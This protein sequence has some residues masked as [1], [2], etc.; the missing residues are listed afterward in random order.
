MKLRIGQKVSA[1]FAVVMALLLVIS[2]TAIFSTRAISKE[3]KVVSQINEQLSLEKDIGSEFNRA[4]AGIRGYIAYGTS[5][6]KDEYNTSMSKVTDAENK[7]LAA[8]NQDKKAEV[9][10]LIE[11]TNTYDKSITGELMPAVERHY[12]AADPNAMQEAQQIAA[13][14]V[15]MTNQ[16]KDIV[17]SL[18]TSN[19]KLFGESIGTVDEV[20]SRVI[21]TTLIFSIIALLLGLGLSLFIA[22][23]VN[24]II[25]ALLGESDKL[26][27]AARE[28]KLDARGDVAKIDPEFQGIIHGMNDTLDAVISPLN[29]AAEYVDRIAKGNTP[30]KI[31]EEYKGDFNE[32]KNNLNE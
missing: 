18:V 19:Q 21:V 29:V 27:E 3:I 9:Q 1:G 24:S 12:Q 26:T 6:F 30:P 8:A 7:L 2:L 28:G 23:S 20:S 14:L 10:K 11:V 31:T 22:K 25:K 5:K 4:V 17:N 32:I 13:L 15:P 16:Q